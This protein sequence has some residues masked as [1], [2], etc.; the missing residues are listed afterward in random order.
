MPRTRNRAEYEATMQTIKRLAR[1]QMAAEGTAALSLRAI[2]RE[3]D[4]T[5]PAL[6]RYY[7]SRDD[8]IT[9]LIVD[10]FNALADAMQAADAACECSQYAGRFRAVGRAYR[11]WALEHPTDFQLIYGNPIP[12]YEAPD[13]V[14]V[15]AVERGFAV[16]AMILIEALAAGVLSALTDEAI[17]P[18]VHDG[19]AR[20]IERDHIPMS[21]AMM[22]L[23]VASWTRIHGM[24]MLELF[25]HTPP[26]VGD[27]NAFY[28]AQLDHMIREL[29]FG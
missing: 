22:Y 21:P 23:L 16:I 11:A 7:P 3:M 18:A 19:L 1:K 27:A 2:A 10:A 29:G 9:A 28:N 14:T 5:A 13:D 4:V 20:I 12:G 8:L 15:P 26:V 25:H 6:Y 17:P 24:V